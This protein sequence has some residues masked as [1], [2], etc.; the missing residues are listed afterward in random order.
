MDDLRAT[1]AGAVALSFGLALSLLRFVINVAVQPKAEVGLIIGF[2][3]IL[4]WTYCAIF[5]WIRGSR[6]YIESRLTSGS[7]P[8]AGND[9]AA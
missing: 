9:A 6:K 1:T 3:A 2:V 4:A 8:V 7:Q 5:Q